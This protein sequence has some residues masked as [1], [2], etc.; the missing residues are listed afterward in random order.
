[1]STHREDLL[2]ICLLQTFH[3]VS[4]RAQHRFGRVR[5]ENKNEGRIWNNRTF[6]DG[7]QNKIFQCEQDLVILTN[8]SRI[9]LK[10]SMGF[11]R[12]M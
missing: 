3:V 4:E 2:M 5:D 1:M 10:L 11:G 8:R 6:N 9:V 7:M 12:K